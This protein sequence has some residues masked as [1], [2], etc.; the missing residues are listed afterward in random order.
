MIE[1]KDGFITLENCSTSKTKQI[2]AKMTAENQKI[3]SK[4]INNNLIIDDENNDVENCD[5]IIIKK[6]KNDE[7]YQDQSSTSQESKIMNPIE[8]ATLLLLSRIAFFNKVGNCL[9]LLL[10]LKYPTLI[11]Y[12][13]PLQAIFNSSEGKYLKRKNII[14][15][16]ETKKSF[17]YFLF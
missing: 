9:I 1:L 10:P 13:E 11:L 7:S 2:N 14:K 12:R 4:I 16:I 15:C 8:T 6:E 5:T 17:L 3:S